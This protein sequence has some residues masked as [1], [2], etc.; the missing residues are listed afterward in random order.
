[1][2][3]QQKYYISRLGKKIKA[4][5]S[6]WMKEQ[7]HALKPFYWQAGYGAFS[8]NPTQVDAVTE[9]IKNQKIHHQTKGYK[10]EYLAFLNKYQQAYDER[11]LW[12]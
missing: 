6:I 12:E 8:V 7:D 2:H 1:M 9:N 4:C 10:E 3:A 5:S 11:Y